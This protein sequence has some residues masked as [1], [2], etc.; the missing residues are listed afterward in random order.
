MNNKNLNH[1][2]E[3]IEKFPFVTDETPH[4]L[5]DF[6]IRESNRTF[7]NG[8]DPLYFKHVADTQSQLLE[9]ESKQ[10]AALALR[11]AYTQGIE[12][13]FALIA[14]AAQAPNCPV[15]WMLR[16]KND[17]LERIVRKIQ[18]SEPILS[19]FNAEFLSWESLSFL[20]H[21]F[22]ARDSEESTRMCNFFANYWRRFAYDF[23]DEIH[24]NE[25]NSVKHGLRLTMGGFKLF[26]GPE[27]TQDAP[28][29]RDDMFCVSQSDFGSMFYSNEKLTDSRNFRVL[30]HSV[31]WNPNKFYVGLYVIYYSISNVVNFLKSL[32][33]SEKFSIMCLSAEHEENFEKLWTDYS[34]ASSLH[35]NKML[36][37]SWITSA[38]KDEILKSYKPLE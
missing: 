19:R 8:I 22:E 17:H 20:L 7:L 36:D 10:Y 34:L 30:L 23:L 38:S 16:Y 32:N 11:S 29:N 2:P 1:V 5:W 21:P 14:S 28:L 4:C 25:Y 18:N 31:N 9:G 3:R 24:K 37:P 6:D 13:L 12:T 33:D 15:G 35:I 26:I 27:K